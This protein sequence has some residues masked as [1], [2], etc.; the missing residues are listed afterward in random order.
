VA[1]RECDDLL[2]ELNDFLHGE[3]TEARKD[4]LRQHLED[5]PPCLETADFQAELRAIV[6]KRCCEQV[7]ESL[8]HRIEEILREPGSAPA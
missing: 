4:S 3:V 5:C 2:Q 7:P 6:A 1:G 8:R